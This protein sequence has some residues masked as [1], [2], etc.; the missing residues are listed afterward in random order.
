MNPFST[1]YQTPYGV[2]PFDIIHFEHFKPALQQVFQNKIENMMIL[3]KTIWKNQHS[4]IQWN[5]WR[6]AAPS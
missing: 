1:E 6:E 4:R 3:K 2:P 5:H